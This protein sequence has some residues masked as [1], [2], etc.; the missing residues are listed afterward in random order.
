MVHLPRAVSSFV[1]RQEEV[2]EARRV[3]NS[4][5]LL[6]LTGPGGVGKT[7]LALRAAAQLR[8]RFPHG[9]WLVELDRL[10]DQALV[11]PGVAAALGLRER[12]DG[13]LTA[14]LA[15]YLAD[16]QLLLVLD[17]CEH[18]LGAVAKLTES[19]LRDT[20]GLRVLATTREP[21]GIDG[22]TVLTVAPLPVPDP[23]SPLTIGQLAGYDAVALFL[24]RA[25]LMV[26][27]FALTEANQVAVAEICARLEGLPLAIELAAARLQALSAGQIRD[28]LTD[29]FS[30]LGRGAR[31]APARQRTLQACLD[32]S[33]R[34]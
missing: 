31:T 17:N 16:R 25:R 1:G 6:S 19:L 13:S 28:R 4:S 14:L 8:R 26:P 7:R 11:V 33:Y 20:R 12:P 21:L 9:V 30:L 32:W 27:G 18:L 3:L 29:Q 15:E 10:H 5:R 2:A 22:E 34:L 24:E 23:G